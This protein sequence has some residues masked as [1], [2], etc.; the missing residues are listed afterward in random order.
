MLTIKN[1]QPA[2]IVLVSFQGLSSE[3]REIIFELVFAGQWHGKTPALIIALRPDLKLYY[4]ALGLFERG[5]TFR[6]SRHNDWLSVHSPIYA[7]TSPNSLR[8]IKT[9]A[10]EMPCTLRA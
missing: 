1:H 4:E 8:Y 6:L 5:N 3:I 9:M 7:T 2:E 10:I